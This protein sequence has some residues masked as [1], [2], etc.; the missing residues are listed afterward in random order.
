MKDLELV[1]ATI[2]QLGAAGKEAFIWWLVFDKFIPGLFFISSIYLLYRLGLHCV[3]EMRATTALKMLRN[4]LIGGSGY[5]YD[6]Q[7]SRVVA[8]VRELNKKVEK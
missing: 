5:L 1:L 3:V 2:A 6:D 8:R 4:E 7:I